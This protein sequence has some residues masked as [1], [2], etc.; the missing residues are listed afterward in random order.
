MPIRRSPT[1]HP[2]K[3]GFG[4]VEGQED[5]RKTLKIRAVSRRCFSLATRTFAQVATNFCLGDMACCQPYQILSLEWKDFKSKPV[6]LEPER[7]RYTWALMSLA[8]TWDS[9]CRRRHACGS[10]IPSARGPYG[11]LLL[12]HVVEGQA[13]TLAPLKFYCIPQ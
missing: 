11:A 6:S 9:S 8:S 5:P 4:R 1:P 10:Q 2:R 12:V 7:E 13:I 3:L